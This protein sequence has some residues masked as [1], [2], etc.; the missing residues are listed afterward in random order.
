VSD[1]ASVIVHTATLLA[2]AVV[3][4]AVGSLHGRLE[5]ARAA[6]VVL[7]AAVEALRGEQTRDR[8]SLGALR[9]AVLRLDSEAPELQEEPP[10]R[11]IGFRSP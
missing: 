7:Q 4:G 5:A 10:E 9:A 2:V 6:I 11:S 3:A 1:P 8:A